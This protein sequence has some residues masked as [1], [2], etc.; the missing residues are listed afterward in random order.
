MCLGTAEA[1]ESPLDIL[2][3]WRYA[4]VITDAEAGGNG[5][6]W[7]T[8]EAAEDEV[9]IL[10]SRSSLGGV[11]RDVLDEDRVVSCVSCASPSGPGLAPVAASEAGSPVKDAVSPARLAESVVGVVAG[12]TGVVSAMDIGFLGRG[13][14][15]S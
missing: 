6:T 11:G 4:V 2:D 14:L 12:F 7:V 10:A 1:T 5:A 9:W 8:L 13:A 3:I 15:K